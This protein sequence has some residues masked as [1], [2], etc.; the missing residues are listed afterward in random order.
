ME[1]NDRYTTSDLVEAQFE[2][3]SDGLVLKNLLGIKDRKEMDRLEADRLR[4]ALDKLLGVYSE[5]YRF[6]EADI[7]K[8]HRMW[9]EGIYPWA[10]VYRRVNLS[11]DEFL[12]AAAD[13]IPLLMADFEKGPL[14]RHTPCNFKSTERVVRALAEVHTELVLIHPFREG[15][16]RVA[17]LLATIMASQAALPVL[18]YTGIKGPKRAEYFFAVRKGLDKDYAPMERI[19]TQVIEETMKSYGC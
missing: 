17:R 19:F 8:I 7:G 2:P 3:G 18:D 5:K 14:F 4:T 15:N 12:F 6:R 9:L 16:G 1:E 10:G 11:K 13:Q